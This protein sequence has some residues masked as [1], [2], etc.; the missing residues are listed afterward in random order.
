MGT[1]F[2][3]IDIIG[4]CEDILLITII[5]LNGYLYFPIIALLLYIQRLR[6]EGIFI[7]VYILDKRDNTA[8]ITVFISPDLSFCLLPPI[9]KD[10]FH[11]PVKKGQF[12][13]TLGQ[14]IIIIIYLIK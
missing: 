6:K 5:I 4:E 9:L 12:P 8:F 14:Y 11:T 2:M 3:G 13:E 10:D 7:P 1:T